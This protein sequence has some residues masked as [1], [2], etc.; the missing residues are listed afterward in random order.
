MNVEQWH[1]T[2]RNVFLRKRVGVRDICRG[3]RQVEMPQGNTLG[4]PRASAGMQDQGNVVRCGL[5]CR[6]SRGS[7]YQVNVAFLVHFHREDRNL[8]VMGCA[9]REFCTH[10]WNE[11][12]A[13]IGVPEKK[14]QLLI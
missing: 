9:A 14:K 10:R 2:K 5:G 13:S 6:D 1:D 8:A 3:Y 12:N 4:P 11:Q 7:S